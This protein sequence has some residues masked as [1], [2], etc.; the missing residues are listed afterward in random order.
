MNAW[1]E[2]P[3]ASQARELLERMPPE[4]FSESRRAEIWRAAEEEAHRPEKRPSTFGWLALAAAATC[5]LIWIPSPATPPEAVAR[6]T[7]RIGQATTLRV[8]R[9]EAPVAVET[10]QVSISASDARFLTMVDEAG[11]SVTV[12]EGSVR[13]ERSGS[14]RTLGPGEQGRWETIAAARPAPPITPVREA[15]VPAATGTDCD[16]LVSTQLG[17]CLTR[18]AAGAGLKAE[19]AWFALGLYERD[20]A[21][22]PEEALRAWDGYLTRFPD[23]VFAPEAA[24]AALNVQV[25]QGRYA[26]AER[27][28]ADYLAR[29]GSERAAGEVALLQAGMLRGPLARPDE[30]G[31]AYDIARSS[32]EPEVAQ[33][34]LFQ[35]ATL[36]FERGESDR[37]RALLEAY[38]ERFPDGL[39]GEEVR[40]WLR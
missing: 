2:T 36:A 5:A 4:L 15:R 34:G 30:A 18:A 7:L 40:E 12:F 26:N 10:P 37:A 35:A 21:G 29:F 20:V 33:E 1:E 31:A 32:S 27:R 9:G 19:N 39:H 11:T 14:A 17:A 23:G 8:R 24:V 3:E 6:V 25:R 38:E 16:A 22:R 28:A 13:V